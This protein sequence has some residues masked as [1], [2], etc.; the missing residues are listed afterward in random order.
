[1]TPEQAAAY[2]NA[3]AALML[4]ELAARKAE[5]RACHWFSKQP[6]PLY[7]SESWREFN[8]KWESILG[9]NNVLTIF[10]QANEYHGA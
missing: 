2:I 10:N 1:M 9:H 8:T 3:Q 6:Y 4:G 5:E 7:E